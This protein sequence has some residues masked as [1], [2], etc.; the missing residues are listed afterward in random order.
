MGLQTEI[1][2]LLNNAEIT[3][4]G[5]RKML[6]RQRGRTSGMAITT[7]S[8]RWP[9]LAPAGGGLGTTCYQRVPSQQQAPSYDQ[10]QDG[11]RFSRKA[12]MASPE[13]W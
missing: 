6:A 8:N 7:Q 12:A 3:I 10:D 4:S 9:A 13:S 2:P 11:S 1:T 5:R